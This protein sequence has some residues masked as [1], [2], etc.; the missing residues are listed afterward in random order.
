MD[1]IIKTGF[2]SI[3]HTIE[4]QPQRKIKGKNLVLAEHVIIFLDL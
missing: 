1:I 3:T 4:F 2:Q